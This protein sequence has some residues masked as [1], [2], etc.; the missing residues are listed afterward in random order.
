MGLTYFK[1]F[2][3][4]TDL[5]G[6]QLVVPPV[7]AGY[8]L[9]PWD[10]SLLETHAE[11]KYHSFRA[12]IDANVF[13]CFC[14]YAGCLRLMREIVAKDGFLPEATW[15]VAYVDPASGQ[16]E[17]C[18]TVQG[19]RDH[20]GV[21]AIQNLGITPEHRDRK[22]GS[23][24][25]LKALEGFCRAGLHGVFLEVTAQNEGAIRLYRRLGFW[26]AKTVYKAVEVAYS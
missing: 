10:A 5:R 26:K 12:E 14:D 8:H 7:P 11:V 17:Y 4:E 20:G 6:R 2:R 3:M 1:R 13:P 22:L 15:L 21:G 19:I 18:G 23:V 9:L 25:M 24:L 16:T